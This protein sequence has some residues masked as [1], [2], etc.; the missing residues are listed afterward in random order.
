MPSTFSRRASAYS[1]RLVNGGS[2]DGK[3]IIQ[4][5]SILIPF[6]FRCSADEERNRSALRT[7]LWE[8][9]RQRGRKEL[10]YLVRCRKRK[11]HYSLS[12]LKKHL[13]CIDSNPLRCYPSAN[14]ARSQMHITVFLSSMFSML[15]KRQT[16]TRSYC[17]KLLSNARH[18]INLVKFF[19]VLSLGQNKTLEFSPRYCFLQRKRGVRQTA[20][21]SL[22]LMKTSNRDSHWWIV[23]VES[24]N[25]YSNL[26]VDRKQ[27]ERKR[28][29]FF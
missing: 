8:H 5:D 7:S 22:V 13:F 11:Y 15:I 27:K 25:L 10:D 28:D 21:E 9:E 17:F 12:T 24:D 23:I 18:H 16:T 4:W 2:D 29:V 1:G 3:R 20:I 26:Q 19:L 14:G 6:V